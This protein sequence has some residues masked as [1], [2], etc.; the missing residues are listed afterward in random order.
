MIRFKI[1]GDSTQ[2]IDSI[3][4][5]LTDNCVCKINDNT[6]IPD[7][8]I[9]I[10]DD[11][12]SPYY[13]IFNTNVDIYIP[14]G[15]HTEFLYKVCDIVFKTFNIDSL[16]FKMLYKDI[17][18]ASDI[19]IRNKANYDITSDNKFS[20][21][22][23][24]PYISTETAKRAKYSSGYVVRRTVESYETEKYSGPSLNRAIIEC[25]KHTGY[26]VFNDEGQVIYISKKYK[27]EL[28]N[29][30]ISD[31]SRHMKI[32]NNGSGI[33]VLNNR[34]PVNIPDGTDVIVSKIS[35]NNKSE[36]IIPF[37]NTRIK[38]LVSNSVLSEV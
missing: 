33:R 5:Y 20:R 16:N 37:D 8:I 22:K 24:D 31:T 4:K 25:D 23:D 15:D 12:C 34:I 2:C 11:E 3:S 30:S 7:V 9:T 19:E 18:I 10:H 1:T 14:T 35:S 27:T 26:K 6:K 29:K 32:R 38:T 21:G 36:I 13:N 28:S 17:S